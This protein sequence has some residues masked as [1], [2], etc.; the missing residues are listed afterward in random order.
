MKRISV[1]SDH[2]LIGTS[3]AELRKRFSSLTVL[4]LTLFILHLLSSNATAQ[5]TTSTIKGTVTDTTGAVIAGAEVKVSGTALAIE[6]TATTDAEGFYRLPA[7]PAGTY[8]LKVSKTGF[9]TS[10]A[11]IELTLNLV[12]TVDVQVKVGNVGEVVNVS[13]EAQPLLESNAS[14]TGATVTPR[15]IMELP[16]NGRDY[17]DLIQLVPGVAI[18]RQA[19]P[20]SDNAN[21]VLGERSGNNNFLI[22]GQPNKDTVNGGAAAQFNQ[23]TIGEFQVL[24]TGFKAEFGQASG[25]VINVITKSGG[26]AYHGVASLFHRNEAFDSVNS[27]ESAVTD[28][29]HLRRFDYSLALGGPIIKDK[30]FFFGS[31]ER[32]TEDRAI[33]FNY[34]DLGPLPGGASVLQLLRNQED[35]FDIPQ[36]S[37]AIRNFFKLDEQFGRHQLV[38]EINYTNEYV[39]GAG[40]GLPTTRTSTSG[41]N[42]LLGFGDTMLLGDQANPWIVTLRGAYRGEPSDSEPAQ[43]GF[44]GETRLNSFPAQQLCPPAC[45]A[46]N[47][48]STLPVITFGNPTT[49]S[50]LF[51]KY[52]SLAANANKRFGAHDFKFGWQ[53]LR[54]KVDG[55]DSRTLT[56]Q[57]FATID[58]FIN[59]GP[60]NSG[61]FLLLTA[62]GPTPESSEIHLRNNYNG[63]YAQDDWKIRKNL[64][65]NLGLRWDYDSEFEARK[66]FSPRLGVAWAITPKTIIR[67]NFGVFYDQFRLGLVQQIPAFGGSDRRVVQSLYFPRG[68][69]GSPS[70]VSM[71][72]FLNRLPGPCISNHLTDA[73]IAAGVVTCPGGGPIVGVDRLNNVVAPGRAPIPANAI[74]NISNVQALT[75]LTP[76]QYLT[77]AA[78]AIGQPAGYFEWGQFGAL[79]N[80]IIPPQIQPTSVDSAFRTP[81]TLGFSIGVQREITTDMVFEAD[82]Y[83][84]EIRN[85]L[86][87]RLSNLAFRS[88]VIG[89]RFDPPNTTGEIRTFGPFFE[90]KYDG[91]VLNLTK[92]LSHRFLL[93][94]NYTYAKATD[95]SL[96]IFTNPTDQFIGVAPVV[97]EPCLPSNPTCTPQTNANGSFITRTGNFVA[98]A[99]TF[100]NGP[101]LDK[102]PSSLALDH[103]FQ[104]NGLVDLPWQFQIGGI[105]RAQ[106]GFHFSRFDAL[107]RDPDGNGNFNGIDFTAGRNAFTA[108]PFVNLD[109]RFS[110][111][112]DIKDRVKIQLLFEFFNLL[113]RQNPRSVQN[114]ENITTEPFG[115]ITQVLSG[116]EGQVGFRI[117]F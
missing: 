38:Q 100:V 2:H 69:Y 63:L 58:D 42:L 45:G 20:G 111:R 72:A 12:L 110:K 54:T 65:L 15:Q 96:G 61:V 13:A 4:V 46:L 105:L 60:V 50:N 21:P 5:T 93:G 25:A 6:R 91:L 115:S 53:F 76:D 104:V 90:G 10:A 95:N 36:R 7:L 83:H 78:S 80:P 30:I 39:I 48:A 59:L 29:L 101:D 87:V 75:G 26:N 49:P 9:A 109:M 55:L 37:R 32:I 33:D 3:G 41:R 31:S 1:T 52:T 114:R 28:P 77:Q 64:T 73:Q 67:S 85:L 16:V 84:R 97:T 62:G 56:N 27:L 112:F 22:D 113:N 18:N 94:A 116:R 35:P 79:N 40:A 34:P 14:S 57:L 8:T 51:Q 24:T 19:N 117:S 44:T 88:R 106:S 70:P 108:L 99:G 71:L 74:I 81:N 103:I 66:N 43:P 107:N 86:G 92:R 11:D 68:F 98:Q 23:E 47:L 82:Y 17:L 89:R 102:G